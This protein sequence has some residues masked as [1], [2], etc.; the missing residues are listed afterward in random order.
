M[1]NH[2]KAPF[3]VFNILNSIIKAKAAPLEQQVAAGRRAKDERPILQDHIKALRQ[4]ISNCRT[5]DP[6]ERR[7][8]EDDLEDKE[9]QLQGIQN[10][11]LRGNLAEQDLQ[12]VHKF[13]DVYST[14]YKMHI[15]AP[16]IRELMVLAE[17][18]EFR[19]SVLE[20]KIWSCEINIDTICRSPE[21]VSQAQY[22][23]DKYF[24]QHRDLEQRLFEIKMKL[25]ELQK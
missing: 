6:S 20:E 8:A 19:M 23:V 17:E 13:N 12:H 5:F 10:R 4:V 2:K 24:S 21:F 9:L 3:A 7:E 18:I 14:A 1:S 16:R 11:I 25:K 22:D 15:N